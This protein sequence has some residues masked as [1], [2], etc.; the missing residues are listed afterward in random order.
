VAFDRDRVSAQL[1]NGFLTVSL[2]KRGRRTIPI[3]RE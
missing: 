3:G 1:A 2:A